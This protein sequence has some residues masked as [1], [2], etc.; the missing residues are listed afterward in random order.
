MYFLVA[1]LLIQ[2]ILLLKTTRAAKQSCGAERFG[3]YNIMYG[4]IPVAV[5]SVP[6]D[7]PFAT[8]GTSLVGSVGSDESADEVQDLLF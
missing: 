7:S 5:G 4:G 2:F 6:S 8:F 3:A 1:L